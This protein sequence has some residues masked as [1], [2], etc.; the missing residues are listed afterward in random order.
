MSAKRAP[1]VAAGLVLG[2]GFGGFVDGIALH[3]LL[4]WHNMLSSVVPPIDLVTMKYNMIW[5]GAFHV[6]TWVACLTGVV[7]LFRAGRVPGA[8]WSGRL[9]GGAMLAGWGLFDLVEGLVDHQLLGLHHVH[10]GAHELAWDLG[11]VTI[12]GVGFLLL[13]AAIM[14]GSPAS[15]ADRHVA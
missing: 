1:L 6:L 2:V 9:L 4:Q 14:R 3:Q 15:H 5:D 11:F 7:L 12:T 8:L 10:P 13:G